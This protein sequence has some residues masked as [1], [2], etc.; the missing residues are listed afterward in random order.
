MDEG[1]YGSFKVYVWVRSDTCLQF[2]V[3]DTRQ[4]APKARRSHGSAGVPLI[5]MTAIT[6]DDGH[7]MPKFITRKILSNRDTTVVLTSL[8]S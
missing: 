7:L 3:A 8:R 6:N 2:P 4:L 5:P 1:L